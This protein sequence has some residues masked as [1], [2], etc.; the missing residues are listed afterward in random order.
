MSAIRPTVHVA[1]DELDALGNSL[2]PYS[3]KSLSTNIKDNAGR[4]ALV[5]LAGE[6][7]VAYK[8]DDISIN[9]Q[10]GIS[11]RDI[12]E[13][14]QVTGTGSVGT[15]KSM[16]TIS[17]GTGVGSALIESVD[18]VRYRSGHETHGAISWIFP[19]PEINVNQYMGFL[20]DNDGWCVG[21]QGTAFGLW[22]IEG[23][24]FN[25]IPQ[26]SWNFDRLDGSFDPT[27]PL[28]DPSNNPSSY[29]INPQ[30][31]NLYRLSYAWHGFLPLV[32][33]IYDRDSRQWILCHMQQST[34]QDVETHLENPS[35]PLA[36]KIE[37]TEGTGAN[38]IAY[39]GSWRAG[40]ITGVSENNSSNRWFSY[41]TLDAPLV[42][43][44]RNNIFT[45]R[46]KATYQGKI[47]HVVVELAVVTFVNDGNKALPIY[48]T[49]NAT[50]SGATAFTDIDTLNST[51]EVSEGGTISG[52]LRS[53]ATVV[54]SGGDRRTD[55]L[56]TGIKI[57]PGETFTFEV[58]TGGNVNGTFSIA[59]RFVGY[60]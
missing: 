36:G 60:H 10:Y 16:A 29:L 4:N 28:S 33:E 13:G 17:T 21:Y 53:P 54:R 42:A 48:G 41:L 3:A 22:F 46:N 30:T 35:L 18:A 8:V 12:V 44:V 55:V 34:N 50:L 19:T 24:N 49:K 56:G 58:P 47:N 52:G 6:L 1:S 37:R 31:A 7:Q 39:T 32:L 57:Y 51:L 15:F 43:S 59:A 23:G 40:S 25:F 5:S 14:G 11:T 27:D 20:N 26:S 45:V 38:L 2:D 9:F